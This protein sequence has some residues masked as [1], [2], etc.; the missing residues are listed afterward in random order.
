MGIV[1]EDVARVRDATDLVALAGEHLALKRVGKRWV[2]LCPFH[3]EKTPSFN[4]NPEMGRFYCF[5]CQANGDAITFVREVEHLDFVDAVERLAARAGITL[6]YDDKAVAKNKGRKERL[7]EAVAAAIEF[8]EELLLDAP[9]GGLARRYL[10]GRG[11]DGDAVRRF[12]LGWSPDDWDRLSVHLQQKGFSRDD[13]SDAGLGFVNKA[14]KLQDQFRARLMFPIFDS[15]GEPVGFGGRALGDDGPKYKNSPETS[16]YQKSRL[17]YGL[18]WAKSEIVARGQIIICEGYTDVMAFALAGAPNAVATCGTALADDHFQV[19]KNLARKVVLAYDADAAGQG[20]AERWYGWEQQFDIQLEVA[21]LPAGRDPADVWR[22]DPQLLLKAVDAAK[23]F[24]EFRID[25]ALGSADRTTLEGRARAAEIA[26]AIIAE[27]PNE[28]VRDQYTMRVGSDLDIDVDRLRAA[29]ARATSGARTG[30]RA[31]APEP[32]TRPT[33]R[34]VD[35]REVDLLLYAVHAPELVEDWIEAKLF[36][37]PVA[38][39]AFEAI[40]A[41]D[42]FHEALD[43]S[44]GDVRDLLERVAVEEPVED[45]EPETLPVR[46]TANAVT[47]AAQRVLAGMLRAEDERSNSV[48]V[49]LNA[50]AN[51]EG[52]GDWDAVQRNANEL[53]GWIADPVNDANT[54]DKNTKR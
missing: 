43:A 11:F 31:R 35:R 42:D 7:H 4:V 46:L 48:K 37:D 29:V 45:E 25:R 21:D 33:R 20:A 9:E 38:R 12:R 34:R 51:A 19:L 6:R 17:L 8:Y 23:P 36:A 22:D 18:N 14:N 2:G 52:I 16:L 41:A 3:A 15:R 30:D 27:H 54:T 44:D 13:L 47:P 10:R 26:A 39:A 40:E 5:G 1:D 28:L 50:L 53:L 49:L 24:M 32:R